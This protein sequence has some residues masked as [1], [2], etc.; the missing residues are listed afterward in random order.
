MREGD[1]ENHILNFYLMILA[2]KNYLKSYFKIVIKIQILKV[3]I[4]IN[5]KFIYPRL[6]N[7]ND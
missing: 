6:T 4:H 2:I 3:K 1:R 5:F 7:T